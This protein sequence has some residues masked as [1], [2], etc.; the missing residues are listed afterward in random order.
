MT[1]VRSTDGQE[2]AREITI[3]SNAICVHYC[4]EYGF[5]VL[6]AILLDCFELR[7]ISSGHDQAWDV[8]EGFEV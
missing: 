2:W 4:T 3:S 5:S 7:D 1:I 8:E 6:V